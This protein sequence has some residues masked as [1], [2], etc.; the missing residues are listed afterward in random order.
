MGCNLTQLSLFEDIARIDSALHG[1][2]LGVR[3]GNA[4]ACEVA[5]SLIAQRQQLLERAEPVDTGSLAVGSRVCVESPEWEP[6]EGVVTGFRNTLVGSQPIIR[7]DS[8]ISYAVL[9]EDEL[10]LIEFDNEIESM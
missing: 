3:V 2:S 9:E 1:L 8:G 10:Y 5:A 4:R 7:F 6:E